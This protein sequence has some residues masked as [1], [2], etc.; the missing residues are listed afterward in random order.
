MSI[1]K[2]TV[3]ITVAIL[4]PLFLIIFVLSEILPLNG[5]KTLEN[6]SM[7]R[8]LMRA[9]EAI[10]GK[11]RSLDR[12]SEDWA[13]WDDAYNY[14]RYSNQDFIA[15]NMT[16]YTFSTT[17][18]NL[19]M[20]LDNQG[21]ILFSKAYD[22]L[23]SQE[24][25]VPQELL[26]DIA[27]GQ[28]L[29]PANSEN[30][31]GIILTAAYPVM[32]V[33]K[34][35][36][37]T[38][39]AGPP[40][41][42]FIAGVFMD[43]N[44]IDTLSQTAH[45]SLAVQYYNRPG[46]PDDF[47]LASRYLVQPAANYIQTLDRNTIAG[48][49][50]L[51]DLWDNP[52]L[53]LRVEMPR[54]IVARGRQAV[55]S[56]HALL[57]LIGVTFIVLFIVLLR[58]TVLSRI[59]TL[60]SQV[61]SIAKSNDITKHIVIPGNDEL[62][63]LAVNINSMINS[64]EISKKNEIIYGQEKKHREELEDEARARTQFIDVLAH[65][66]RNPL[67]PILV[68]VEMLKGLFSNDTSSVQYRMAD[69]A[70]KSTE[71]L[72]SRLEELLDMARFTRGALKLKPQPVQTS[73]FLG[74]I[75]CR[76]Q[77]ALEDRKQE[78]LIQIPPDLPQVEADP[79]RLEQVVVNLLSNACKYSPEKSV[80]TFKASIN[81]NSVMVEIADHG[82]GIEL[83]DQKHLF[84]PYHRTE[85]ARQSFQ[86]LGLGLSVSRHIIEA[87]GGKIW[88]ESIAGKGS[89]FKFTLPI[90]TEA[91][92]VGVQFSD[93]VSISEEVLLVKME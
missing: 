51:S 69:N 65:E 36:L 71:L 57:V 68:S 90:K 43:S 40:A 17:E 64:L 3:L 76:Y 84:E 85:Q 12:L 73:Q 9:N 82:I 19:M 10:S 21:K 54:D 86:G 20:F 33:I 14:V 48:Y 11:I 13:N 81:S 18:V 62:S 4:V 58:K 53:I 87:H 44:M 24:I 41:G 50:L 5:F 30:T 2:K 56:L 78:L 16:D 74:Y 7:E 66:L 46:I 92:Q 45:L 83:E 88:V 91:S 72:R 52:A 49:S 25:P 27:Q 39:G 31:E 70:M 60:D 1:T 35:I 6:E 15:T 93:P 29:N 61:V 42:T 32:V 26:S 63:R 89:T 80:I 77:P 55:T 8:D 34:P 67:T 28:L 37:T 38:N 79:S 59:V 47:K 22:L 75:A 23:N